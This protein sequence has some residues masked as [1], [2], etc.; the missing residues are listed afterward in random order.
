MNF[1]EILQGVLVPGQKM[2]ITD[3]DLVDLL[4]IHINNKGEKI[5]YWINFYSKWSL[6]NTF[7]FLGIIWEC[8]SIPYDIR[9]ASH[10]MR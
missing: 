9:S 7:T 4:K 6:T 3:H 5:Y 1:T 10:M 8:N 2:K